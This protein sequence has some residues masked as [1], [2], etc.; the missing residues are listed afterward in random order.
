MKKVLGLGIVFASFFMLFSCGNPVESA[1]K[2]M[3][4]AVEK[5][6]VIVKDGTA[7]VKSVTASS[8]IA[9]AI[10]AT[11]DEAKKCISD[12]NA[13]IEKNQITSEQQIKIEENI[14]ATMTEKF[15]AIN[16]FQ[17]AIGDSIISLSTNQAGVAEV[18]NALENSKAV[19]NF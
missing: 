19:L 8:E 10:S 4:A 13:V 2:D 15:N 17:K 6:I 14:K 5:M 3:K 9:G 16:E 11:A 7:K 1:Q 12:Y 18:Q